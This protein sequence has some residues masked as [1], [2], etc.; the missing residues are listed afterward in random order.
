MGIGL[1]FL[2]CTAMGMIQMISIIYTK[3]DC[4]KPFLSFLCSTNSVK[5][6][7]TSSVSVIHKELVAD[8]RRH[9]G[10]MMKVTMAMLMMMKMMRIKMMTYNLPSFV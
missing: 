9:K 1:G 8:I 7:F 10:I 5:C 4:C 2:F 3:N 6:I